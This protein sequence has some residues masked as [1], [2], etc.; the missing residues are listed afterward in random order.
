MST[1][2]QA[3]GCQNSQNQVITADLSTACEKQSKVSDNKLLSL[4]SLATYESQIKIQQGK[5]KGTFSRT[6]SGNVLSG[7]VRGTKQFLQ[8]KGTQKEEETSKVFNEVLQQ[9]DQL[10]SLIGNQ[11]NRD[12]ECDHPLLA[13]NCDHDDES[14]N[15]KRK[16]DQSPECELD[17]T[18][19]QTGKSSNQVA[20]VLQ[21][22]EVQTTP[23]RYKMTTQQEEDESFQTFLKEHG[24]Q[25]NS[26]VID[27]I[28]VLE[29]FRQ[30]MSKKQSTENDISQWKLQLK[31]ELN[32]DVNRTAELYEKRITD[33][34]ASLRESDRK[35]DVVQNVVRHQN[36]IMNDVSKRLDNLEL[37]QARRMAV[38]SGL[39]IDQQKKE[40][41][42]RRVSN[43]LQTELELFTRLEDVYPLGSSDPP[44]LVI[45]FQT[46]QDKETVFENKAKLKDISKNYP[47]KIYLNHYLPAQENER[48]KRDRKITMDA[49]QEN[50]EAT[51][52]KEGI[53]VGQSVYKKKISPPQ[54]IELLNYTGAEM[55]KILKLPSMK[56]PEIR[57]KGSVYI[58][59][60]IDVN[61]YQKVRD[62]YMKIR[63]L[64]AQA[65]HIVCAFS[66][67]GTPEQHHHLHDSCD[68]GK[69]GAGSLLLSEMEKANIYCKAFYIVRYTGTEKLGRDRLTEVY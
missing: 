67:P 33:L 15:K 21:S 54:P 9:H 14:V 61:D 10:T 35:L 59:Y 47:N 50:L 39:K 65:R 63:I 37:N 51:F 8:S 22:T 6:P 64:H 1:I 23:K 26:K 41:R 2:G 11:L 60:A 31:E 30:I 49:K 52:V 28:T 19:Q 44:A 17:Q 7:Q 13:I 69:F 55:D 46:Y 18:T 25:E 43:F 42:V 16:H 27:V 53:K 12:S 3:F 20:S 62:V 40:D 29:M 68:D 58:P 5:P 34:E 57:T 48:R 32:A 36:C 45:T 4:D 66:L 56:G 38:L 24:V